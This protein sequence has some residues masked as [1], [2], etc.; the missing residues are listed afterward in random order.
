MTDLDRGSDRVVR[1][2]KRFL[3][4]SQKYEIVLQLVQ[5]ELGQ[6]LPDG[7]TWRVRFHHEIRGIGPTCGVIAWMQVLGELGVS[8]SICQRGTSR[9]IEGSTD[10]FG[11]I[12]F[13]IR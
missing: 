3:S 10:R 1:R 4:P 5:Q 9:E 12:L 2:A 7:P 6:E 11:E 13:L 8:G